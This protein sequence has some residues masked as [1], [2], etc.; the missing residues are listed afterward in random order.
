MIV[1][2]PPNLVLY[3]T[4]TVERILFDEVTRASA[5]QLETLVRFSARNARME[6]ASQ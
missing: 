5:M 6:D 1:T 2:V 3:R 4:V